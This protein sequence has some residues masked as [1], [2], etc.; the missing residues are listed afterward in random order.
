MQPLERGVS[1]TAIY[2]AGARTE[3][4]VKAAFGD[5]FADLTRRR[6]HRPPPARFTGN[7]HLQAVAR[8]A[9][10]AEPA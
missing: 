4:P 2:D 10:L 5:G 6:L 8:F 3:D 1:V 7:V 9:S